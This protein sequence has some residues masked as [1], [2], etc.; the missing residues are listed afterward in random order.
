MAAKE[1]ECSMKE[2]VVSQEID[3]PGGAEL[4]AE[5]RSLC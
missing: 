3:P 4:E 2:G 1:R 5:G